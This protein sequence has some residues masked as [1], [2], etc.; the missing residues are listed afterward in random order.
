MPTENWKLSVLNLPPVLSSL[1]QSTTLPS[2][3]PRPKSR[4]AHAPE[5]QSSRISTRRPK[6]MMNSSIALSMT[7][8]RST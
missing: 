4:I 8:F 5:F 7:S 2:G 6:P 1:T 3:M